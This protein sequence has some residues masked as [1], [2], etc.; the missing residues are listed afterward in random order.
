MPGN[1]QPSYRSKI[2]KC[3]HCNAN[4]GQNC[5]RTVL[6]YLSETPKSS[7]DRT[8]RDVK[9]WSSTTATLNPNFAYITIDY[10][11]KDD[12]TGL[13]SD[14]SPPF[15]VP[16]SHRDEA[17]IAGIAFN[18]WVA[19][20]HICA[21]LSTWCGSE[22]TY[23]L[24]AEGVSPNEDLPEGI[25]QI[26]IEA[27]LVVRHSPRAAAALLRSTIEVICNELKEKGI[28][29]FKNATS[30]NDRSEQAIGVG[31]EFALGSDEA[32]EGGA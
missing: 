18:V 21:G 8:A 16:S 10:R 29:D 5:Y 32:I 13:I 15:I 31:A 20:C 26:F 27:S 14:E 25:K 22:C 11:K 3:S 1:I 12:S 7:F 23:P 17:S 24:T 9:N 19:E 2:F 28:F 4:T 30:L 6:N